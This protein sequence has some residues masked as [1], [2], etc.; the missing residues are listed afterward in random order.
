VACSDLWLCKGSRRT[1]VNGLEHHCGSIDI[2]VGGF[3]A[4]MWR[5]RI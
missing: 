1:L 5:R 3:K 4:A 2:L